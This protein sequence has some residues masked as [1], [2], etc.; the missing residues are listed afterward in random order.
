MTL[1]YSPRMDLVY[2]YCAWNTK[3]SF[4]NWKELISIFSLADWYFY[5]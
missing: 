1:I 2:L 3:I 5:E 4:C